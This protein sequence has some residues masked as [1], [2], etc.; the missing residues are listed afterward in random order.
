MRWQFTAWLFIPSYS[1]HHYSLASVR[2]HFSLFSLSLSER[3]NC[4]L[5]LALRQ[6]LLTVV[7]GA[8]I[9]LFDFHFI[10]LP[11][12]LCLSVCCSYRELTRPSLEWTCLRLERNCHALQARTMKYS[13]LHGDPR[14]A[15]T[16]EIRK[17]H[18]MAVT[19]MFVAA[20]I[21]ELRSRVHLFYRT[22]RKSECACGNIAAQVHLLTWQR[23]MV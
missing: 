11:L 16:A 13:P 23:R 18:E 2:C 22:T 19:G 9:S 20:L 7:D 15:W 6:L 17:V 5:P 10:A 21:R 8:G 4:T 1:T 3:I 12:S 14:N